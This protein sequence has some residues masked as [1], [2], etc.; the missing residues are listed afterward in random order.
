MKRSP[1]KLIVAIV[2]ILLMFYVGSLTL[3]ICLDLYAASVYYF[4]ADQEGIVFIDILLYDPSIRSFSMVKAPF[5][6]DSSHMDIVAGGYL[7][8]ALYRA[9]FFAALTTA[10][11]FINGLLVWLFSKFRRNN[12]PKTRY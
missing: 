12:R 8:S 6:T 5:L 3:I 7:N 9:W 1:L 2:L 10:A 11:V 4:G